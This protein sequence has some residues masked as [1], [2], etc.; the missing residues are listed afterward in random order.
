MASPSRCA[1][2]GR[3]VASAI[4]ALSAAQP[5]VNRG[6]AGE[7]SERTVDGRRAGRTSWTTD[8]VLAGEFPRSVAGGN[9]PSQLIEPRALRINVSVEI[10]PALPT[11][12]AHRSVGRR[13]PRARHRRRSP[14]HRRH[15][16]SR[17]RRAARGQVDPASEREPRMHRPP[18]AARALDERIIIRRLTPPAPVISSPSQ[19]ELARDVLPVPAEL[20]IHDPIPEHPRDQL[21]MLDRPELGQPIHEAHVE[22]PP[23]PPTSR[24]GRRSLGITTGSRASTHGTG[25]RERRKSCR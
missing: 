3:R 21:R 14:G 9:T 5:A 23:R 10:D 16:P 25:P 20:R 13:A 19:P 22:R 6:E 4:H 18:R 7:R 15:P 1:S 17:R 12:S 11:G 8:H 2:R 24:I